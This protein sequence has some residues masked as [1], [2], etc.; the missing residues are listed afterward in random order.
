MARAPARPGDE[1]DV[2]RRP[3]GAWDHAVRRRHLHHVA[4][5]RRAI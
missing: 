2:A 1:A 3:S 5:A 4:V